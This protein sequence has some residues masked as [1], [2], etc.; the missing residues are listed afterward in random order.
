MIVPLD[1]NAYYPGG[2]TLCINGQS[3][4]FASTHIDIQY[5]NFLEVDPGVYTISM[6]LKTNQE[7]GRSYCRS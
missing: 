1:F 5:R 7:D 4:D 6:Y 3:E 2:T